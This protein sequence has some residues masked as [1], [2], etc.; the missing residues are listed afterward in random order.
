MSSNAK[1][2]NVYFDMVEKAYPH[3]LGFNCG[4]DHKRH[5]LFTPATKDCPLNL[6]GIF[7]TGTDLSN[8]VTNTL[9]VYLIWK[10]KD[11]NSPLNIEDCVIL[12][13]PIPMLSNLINIEEYMESMDSSEKKMLASQMMNKSSLFWVD[14]D[15]YPQAEAYLHMKNTENIA[16]NYLEEIHNNINEN[17]DDSEFEYDDTEDDYEYDLESDNSSSA[18][19]EMSDISEEDY[20]RVISILRTLDPSIKIIS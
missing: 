5:A 14:D 17:I 16:M 1:L 6:Y 2:S 4:Y 13:K 15:W 9:G 19:L 8:T 12:D 3:L 11:T 18:M 20:N 7:S 10:G